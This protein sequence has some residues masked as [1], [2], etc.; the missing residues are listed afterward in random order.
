VT[1]RRRLV[2]LSLVAIAAC[3]PARVDAPMKPG[4][5]APGPARAAGHVIPNGLVHV[6]LVG[7]D[8]AETA[9]LDPDDAVKR[10]REVER[11]F[12]ATYRD[13]GHE[14]W[15]FHAFDARELVFVIARWERHE[16]VGG[17]YV[18]TKRIVVPRSDD[19]ER[20]LGVDATIRQYEHATG[21]V[22]AGMNTDEVRAA[23]GDP[24]R[25]QPLGPWGAFDWVY[26]DACVRF[27]G[28]RVA[29]VWSRDACVPR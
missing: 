24:E 15:F 18:A 9:T 8:D 27:L 3:G 2:A 26:P 17:S 10:K 5:S 19:A 22:K 7:F 12:A 14:R 29:H 13:D 20:D 6:T 11:R 16:P 28:N 4:T 1:E 23:R 21:G 25:E